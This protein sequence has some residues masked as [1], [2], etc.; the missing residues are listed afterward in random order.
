MD[1][2]DSYLE[3]QYNNRA[4]VPEHPRF[5]AGWAERS[6]AYREHH[7]PISLRYGSGERQWLDVFP[8]GPDAPVH[9]F[10]HGGYWQALDRHSFSFMAEAFNRAGECAVILQYDLCPSV[11]LARIGEQIGQAL[12]WVYDHVAEQG[13]DPGRIRVTGHSA[14]AHLAV[15]LLAR[16]PELP[17]RRVDALS[18]L[19]DLQPLVATSINGALGLDRDS[20]L[21]ESPLFEQP[22]SGKAEL[23]LWVGSQESAEYHRQSQRLC[24]AWLQ[25]LPV[26]LEVLPA[27]HHFSILDAFLEHN[28]YRPTD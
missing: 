11:S 7:P 16:C 25:H 3:A 15:R 12:T 6:R 22:M 13:G 10:I 20:A 24:E 1:D 28:G 27:T 2:I 19:Y 21:A 23:A 26:S 18:G 17:L 4:A 9:V 5:L 14:G 8:A